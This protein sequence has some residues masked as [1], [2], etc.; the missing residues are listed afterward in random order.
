MRPTIVVDGRFV[1]TWA[2][3]R[4]GGRLAVTVEPFTDARPGVEEAIDAEIDDIGRFEGLTA[5]GAAMSDPASRRR[6]YDP[7]P[8]REEGSNPTLREELRS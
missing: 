3:K 8:T 4:A 5:N 7:A 1:G 2:S 6:R